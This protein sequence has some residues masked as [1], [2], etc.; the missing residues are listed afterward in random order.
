MPEFIVKLDGVKLSKS[1]EA[2]LNREIQ[3]VVIREL[4]GIDY[5][6]DLYSKIPWKE[7][8]GIW[9]KNKIFDK[10]NVGLEVNEMIGR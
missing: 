3:A 5:G 10:P 1:A 7:W 8:R 4:A 6:G 2:S 9:V